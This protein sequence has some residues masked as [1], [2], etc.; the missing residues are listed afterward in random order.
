MDKITKY[1]LLS[2]GF[3]VFL[4]RIFS[5]FFQ[6]LVN[7]LLARLLEPHNMALYFLI[8]S[9]VNFFVIFSLFGMQRSI[10]R[11]ITESL[12]HKNI[13]KARQVVCSALQTGFLTSIV[14]SLFFT[15]GFGHFVAIKVFKSSILC[16]IIYIP[17]IWLI[18]FTLQSLIVESFRGY[19]NIKYATIFN[20]LFSSILNATFFSYLLFTNKNVSINLIL[21]IIVI[22][23]LLNLI[24]S[25]FFLRP[26]AGN[27][28]KD[29][30]KIFTRSELL[31]NSWVLYLTDIALF[32]MT[33]GQLWLLSYLSDKENVA[34]FGAATRLMIIVTTALKMMKMTV[35]PIIG[36]LYA[37]NNNNQVEKV[38]RVSATFAGIPA[39]L[40]LLLIIMFGNKLL[41]LIYGEYYTNGYN[42]L[43]ILA[44]A[45]LV[46]VFTGSPGV[47]I[48]M[49]SKEKYLLLFA[50]LSGGFGITVSYLLIGGFQCLGSSIGTGSGI[51]LYNL[52]M[53]IYCK[54]TLSINTMMSFKKSYVWLTHLKHSLYYEIP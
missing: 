47:L 54:Y 36:D 3:W 18:I 16:T 19:H 8:F 48:V 6:L 4:G 7:G 42:A 22:S 13:L 30:P 29:K 9:L 28:L 41:Y 21:H 14:V 24:V 25:L 32:F 17:I 23:H 50:I 35:L 45:N 51:A 37:K 33:S 15:L 38:L 11:I 5:V 39:I 12:A 52:M 20:G 40:G 49:A 53:L 34:Y 27:L 43:I 44:I 31:K 2:G 26:Y 46:N 1:R 10:V